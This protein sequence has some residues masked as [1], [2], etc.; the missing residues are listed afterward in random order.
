MK[1]KVVFLADCL[2]TQK[3]GIHYYALQFI[4]RTIAK[5]TDHD[6]YIVVPERYNHLNVN[7]I[8]IPINSKIPFHLRIRNIWHIPKSINKL[9]PDIVIEMAH[10]GPF[11]LNPNIK[12]VTVIHDLTA[13]LYPEWHDKA[14]HIV[15]KLFLKKILKK[16]DHII[17]NS[18]STA[19]S[20]TEY[21]PLTKDKISVVYPSINV[22]D[23]KYNS[24]NNK[25]VYFLSVGTIEPR[26]NYVQ[27]I[28]AFEKVA[29]DNREVQL[30]IIGY[31]GWKYEP[32]INTIEKSTY[33]D[34]IILK[35]YL[36]EE[37]LMTYYRHS[38]AFVFTTLYEGFGIPLL[39]AMS[40]GSV[41]ISSDITIS[42]E[43]CGHAALY[44]KDTDD[45]SIKMID[46]LNN[47]DSYT[48]M[49]KAALKQAIAI[50]SVSIDLDNIL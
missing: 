9:N 26:K 2:I 39:E 29:A 22:H 19:K 16:A 35:G 5:Y 45:L 49:R 11:R 31:K 7:Q 46:V 4:K 3:A 33:S 6:Y 18:H 21:Q 23:K 36:S 44:Y 10:F 38:I 27:L 48:E 41:I 42:R 8:I 30:V 40:L 15:Q 34:R 12:R 32:V 43:V 17:T 20:I 50:N 14:S 1:K 13:V 47:Q 25:G 28:K 24:S 37:E